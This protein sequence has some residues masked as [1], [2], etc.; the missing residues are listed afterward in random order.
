MVSLAFLCRTTGDSSQQTLPP[1]P[2]L[3]P[4]D[5]T[6]G[7]AA[8]P[9]SNVVPRLSSD[10]TGLSESPSNAWYW[11]ESQISDCLSGPCQT[12]ISG[13]IFF[14]GDSREPSDEQRRMARNVIALRRAITGGRTRHP[15]F[16]AALGFQRAGPDRFES[17]RTFQTGPSERPCWRQTDSRK[18]DGPRYHGRTMPGCRP[19]RRGPRA[20]ASEE[21]GRPNPQ[22]RALQRRPIH[23]CVE[24]KSNSAA[25]L[26]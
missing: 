15:H 24:R 14:G 22:P 4:C 1:A 10:E 26:A 8:P 12:T 25:K 17:H 13:N 11:V 3:A 21:G 19:V 5:K 20:T 6:F 16:F 23:C 18:A 7:P 9:P 2:R